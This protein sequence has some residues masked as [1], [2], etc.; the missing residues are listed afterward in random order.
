[1]NLKK[2]LYL[3]L[4]TALL[5]GL[6]SGCSTTQQY[7]KLGFAQTAEPKMTLDQLIEN[8]KDYRIYYSGVWEGH[9]Y[10]VMFDPRDDDRELVGHEWWAPVETQEDLSQMIRLINVYPLEPQL[11]KIL[12]PDDQLHGF[13]Y[14]LKHPVIV[15]VIDDQTLWVDDL[16]F[17]P[18]C[19]R[20]G[21]DGRAH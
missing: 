20:C 19:E 10:G 21:P 2:C 3:G 18:V 9:V 6:T 12:S 7:G 5:I 13:I 16:T 15:K 11:W 4:I 8:W 1:M 14:T 17:P